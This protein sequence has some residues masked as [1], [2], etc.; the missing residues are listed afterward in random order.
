MKELLEKLTSYNLF[1]YLL[2]G[3]LV[4][5]LASEFGP[6][7]FTSANLFVDLFGYYFLGLVISR[8]GSLAIEP[9]LKKIGFLKFESYQDFLAASEKDSKLEMLS[10][11]N[12]MYRT[13]ASAFLVLCA[14]LLF[15]KLEDFFP[16]LKSFDLYLGIGFL[17]VLF[18]FSY[19][20][21]TS[22]ISS[23]IRRIVS[24]SQRGSK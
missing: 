4:G 24:H 12:N 22:Y 8:I 15:C 21:Q 11:S 2:P 20:K 1:N 23:R 18:L 14:Y 10:E 19:K 5:N 9:A 3:V 7:D 6:H 16:K 13:L 17:V